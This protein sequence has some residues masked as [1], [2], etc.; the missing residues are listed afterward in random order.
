MIEVISDGSPEEQQIFANWA[1]RRLQ[2][3]ELTL[4]DIVPFYAYAV[5]RN[6]KAAAVVLWNNYR[7]LKHGAD[8]R[9]II[10]ADD[11]KWC[12]PG[13]LRELF[14]YPFVHLGCTRIT[15]VIKDGNARSLKL[16]R[17]LGFR[18]EGVLRRGYNGKSNAIV[19]SML[20]EECEW[21]KPRKERL[22]GKKEHT[23]PSQAARSRKNGQGAVRSQQRGSDRVDAPKRNRHIRANGTDDVRAQG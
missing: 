21:L 7:R 19:L 18:K 4:E 1:L 5:K 11:P 15:A 2:D 3:E 8:I 14:A 17:G 9:V 10:A 22:D 16:C 13:V 20:R 12:L 6:G 23:K